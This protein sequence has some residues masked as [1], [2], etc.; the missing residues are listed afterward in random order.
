LARIVRSFEAYRSANTGWMACRERAVKPK[1]QDSARKEDKKA[2]GR[3]LTRKDQY[4]HE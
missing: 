1:Q 2:P 3:G 4:G